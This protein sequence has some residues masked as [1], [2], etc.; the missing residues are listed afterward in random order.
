[1]R[2]VVAFP[3]NFE[4]EC[5]STCVAGWVVLDLERED[6]LHDELAGRDVDGSR[7]VV[8]RRVRCV[9]LQ[10][11]GDVE[12]VVAVP[13]WW[14]LDA[15]RLRADSGCDGVRSGVSLLELARRLIPDEQVLRREPYAVAFCKLKRSG[16]AIG[17]DFLIGV[18]DF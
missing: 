2:A 10:E 6:S 17:I 7:G 11:L 12:D 4:E 1:M 18:S 15:V 8:R 3:A 5:R 14:Y 16:F 13:R 9:A